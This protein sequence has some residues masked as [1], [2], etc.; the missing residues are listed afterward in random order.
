[1]Q[2]SD[3]YINTFLSMFAPANPLAEVAKLVDAPS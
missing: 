2:T 1:M 3:L